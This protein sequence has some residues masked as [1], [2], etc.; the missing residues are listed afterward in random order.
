MSSAAA[1]RAM[2]MMPSTIPV[3]AAPLLAGLLVVVD[4]VQSH[5]RRLNV[6]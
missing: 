5:P 3:V 6:R 4:S 1:P 2:P